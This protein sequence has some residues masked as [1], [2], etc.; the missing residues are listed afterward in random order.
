VT[1]ILLDTHVFLWLQ[2]DPERLSSTLPLLADQDTTL[3]LSA[4][5]SWEIAVKWGFGKLLLPEAPDT[6]VPD[7]MQRDAIDAL[8][9][10]HSHALAVAKL[11]QHHRDPF[12][13]LLIAQAMSERIPLVTAD[14]SMRAY[15]AEL[16]WV[17]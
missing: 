17:G 5:S 7:R 12:D 2:T 1:T 11:P 16:L 3:L 14:P 4:A 15:A 9:I 10:L 8:P 6:Y 13:R